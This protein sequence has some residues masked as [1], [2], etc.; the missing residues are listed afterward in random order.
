MHAYLAPIL[1]G[2][3]KAN[4]CPTLV[5]GG[6][7][8]HVHALFVLSKNH[9]IA[10]IVYEMKRSCSKWVKSSTEKVSLAEWLWCVLSKPVSS[11]PL[12]PCSASSIKL[13]ECV[14]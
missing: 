13:E 8:D 12:L 2:I 10:S 3:L 4:K 11:A 6:V 9:S 5:V 1:K 14:Q 7:P